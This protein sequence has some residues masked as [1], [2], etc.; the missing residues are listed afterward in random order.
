MAAWFLTLFPMVRSVRITSGYSLHAEAKEYTHQEGRSS[1]KWGRQVIGAS[2]DLVLSNTI[3]GRTICAMSVRSH[4]C[5]Q[6]PG[7]YDA[8]RLPTSL[9]KP[10]TI[11]SGRMFW[12]QA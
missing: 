6:Q 10:L 11:Q 1:N 8:H 5:K 2:I 3:V 7:W 9:L 4:R 12:N